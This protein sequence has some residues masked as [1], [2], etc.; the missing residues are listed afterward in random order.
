MSK[1]KSNG[2]RY[3]DEIGSQYKSLLTYTTLLFTHLNE[4]HNYQN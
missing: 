3:N 2:N 4:F 1:H